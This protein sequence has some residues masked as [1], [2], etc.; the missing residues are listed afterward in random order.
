VIAIVV[1]IVIFRVTQDFLLWWAG[2]GPWGAGGSI[3]Q[4]WETTS[5]ALFRIIRAGGTAGN[6]LAALAVFGAYE[7]TRDMRRDLRYLLWTAGVWNALAA[8]AYPAISV[9]LNRGD[10]AWFLV[11]MEPTTFWRLLVTLIAGGIAVA[12]CWESAM[13]LEAFLDRGPNRMRIRDQAV[14]APVLAALGLA[15]LAQAT[16]WSA[17][18]NPLLSPL[19]V[20]AA[21]VYFVVI[22]RRAA[23]PRPHTPHRADAILQSRPWAAGAAAAV[24]VLALLLGR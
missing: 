24:G 16:G 6:L 15:L 21:A 7:A 12:A 22:A 17:A 4:Q 8:T 5:P 23:L 13:T 1:S 10:W 14:T 9:A 18:S 11:G 19:V 3:E 20:P 2:A